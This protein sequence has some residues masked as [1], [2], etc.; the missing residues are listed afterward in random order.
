MPLF[1]WTA[2]LACLIQAALIAVV[3]WDDPWDGLLSA[4]TVILP[5][6]VYLIFAARWRAAAAREFGPDVV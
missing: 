4:L 5:V 6:P 2:I 3:V 1:P